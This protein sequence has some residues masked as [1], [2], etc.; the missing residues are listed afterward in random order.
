M[1]LTTPIT[2]QF[3]TPSDIFYPRTKCGDSRFSRSGDTIAG[4]EIYNGSC[5]HDHAPSK[6]GL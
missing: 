2:G 3:V 6:D 1:T 4:I 5:D